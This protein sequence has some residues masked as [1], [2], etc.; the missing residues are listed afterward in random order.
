MSVETCR[1]AC[2]KLSP[3]RALTKI[4]LTKQPYMITHDHVEFSPDGDLAVICT[5]NSS[6]GE[7]SPPK[8]GQTGIVF[9][10]VATFLQ[11]DG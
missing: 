11:P 4:E 10:I 5:E 1:C 6:P 9:L 3:N 2:G 8:I 7:K